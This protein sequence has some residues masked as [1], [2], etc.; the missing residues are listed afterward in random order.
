MGAKKMATS[1]C[2]EM[3]TEKKKVNR[4]SRKRSSDNILS[5]NDGDSVVV[6]QDQALGRGKDKRKANW[7]SLET[8]TLVEQVMENYEIVYANHTGSE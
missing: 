8:R 7:T 5:D 4:L 1:R 2:S 6:K 3:E